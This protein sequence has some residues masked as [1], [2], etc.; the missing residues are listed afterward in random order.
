MK[1]LILIISA[2]L[3]IGLN[4]N[5]SA[6]SLEESLEIAGTNNPLLKAK[7]AEFEAALQKAAQFNSLPDPKFSFGYFV[8]PIETRLG[9]QRAKLSLTQMFPWFG[10]LKI[11]ENVQ[12]LQAESKYQEFLDAKNEL[13]MQVKS[14]WHP[15]Y[16]VNQKIRLQKKNKDILNSYKQLATTRFKNNKSSMVDV[17]RVEIMIENTETEIELL[18]NQ[19]QPLIVHFNKLLHRADSL[20]VQIEQ[21]LNLID[22][23]FNYRKDS[24]FVNQPLLQSLDLKMQSAKEAESLGKKRGLPKFG[25]GLDYA[26]IEERTDMEVS[27]NGRNV[28]MPMVSMSI[29]IY[30]GKYKSAIKEAQFKQS[31]IANYKANTE[32]NLVSKYETAYYELDKARQ[33][34]D[35]HK[36][37]ISKTKQAISLLETAYSNSGKNFEEIL[38]MQ[39]ELLKYQIATASA[40]KSFYIALAKLDYLTSKTE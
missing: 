18:Q 17:I 12:A 24:L 13:Y 11:A 3:L 22:V 10:T 5:V 37:Q 7:Y 16:E 35:L 15:I 8:S 20:I 30:R 1:K 29:P 4:T 19:L 39:Q 27:D 34:I 9:A 31:A 33:L 40:T 25:I 28:L 2:L 23:P 14:A 36:T 26:F 6:Q 38:R 21:E 32:N